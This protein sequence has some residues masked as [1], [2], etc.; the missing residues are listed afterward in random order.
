MLGKRK[1]FQDATSG[2]KLEENEELSGLPRQFRQSSA[3]LREAPGVS[4]EELHTRPPCPFPLLTSCEVAACATT[5][6]QSG[7]WVRADSK[8]ASPVLG[9]RPL[10]TDTEVGRQ[11]AWLQ[12]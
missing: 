11:G 5:W 4:S 3:G 2:L 8:K 9:R 12:T 7:L 10:R 6:P 1:N